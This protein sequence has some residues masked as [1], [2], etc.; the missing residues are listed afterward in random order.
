MRFF[1]M[2][3][4]CLGHQLLAGAGLAGDEHGGRRVGDLGDHLVDGV[5][6]RAA[7]DQAEPAVRL[8]GL[9]LAGRRLQRELRRAPVGLA[10]LDRLGHHLP[11]LL[12][13]ERL[14]DVVEGT[15]LDRRHGVVDA[16]EGGDHDD[17]R[18]R[19]PARGLA[20]HLHAV[21]AR[22]LEVGDHHVDIAGDELQRLGAIGGLDHGV[23]LA[24]QNGAEDPPQVGFVIRHQDA[25]VRRHAAC[26]VQASSRAHNSPD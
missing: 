23:A 15:G 6:L 18:L 19:L 16:A 7:A 4:Q 5:H 3:V 20:Q 9:R 2:A 21:D 14:L 24:L 10:L 13:L 8:G 26:N 22:H 12:L 17:R 1:G 11:D 25:R